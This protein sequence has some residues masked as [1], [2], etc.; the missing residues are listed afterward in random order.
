M[1]HTRQ[2]TISRKQRRDVLFK[3]QLAKQNPNGTMLYMNFDSTI[4]K[5]AYMKSL[6]QL[7]IDKH[8]FQTVSGSDKCIFIA[9]SEN[10][11]LTWLFF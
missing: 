10:K 5:Q 1:I 6:L 2:Y 4:K 11:T 8:L 3:H 9:D 7:K